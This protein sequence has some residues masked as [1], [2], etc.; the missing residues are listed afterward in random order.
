MR[1]LTTSV[2][3]T[4]PSSNVLWKPGLSRL[5]RLRVATF[6]LTWVVGRAGHCPGA[7]WM[8]QRPLGPAIRLS[9]PR[10]R[11]CARS[12]LAATP[13]AISNTCCRWVIKPLAKRVQFTRPEV[14]TSGLFSLRRAGGSFE[15]DIT[16]CSRH[17]H[18]FHAFSHVAMRSNNLTPGIMGTYLHFG[19]LSASFDLLRLRQAISEQ[20]RNH[21]NPPVASFTP[22]KAERKVV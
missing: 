18:K 21:S 1:A 19:I 6:N 12:K 7:R 10:L 9:T 16:I 17:L 20:N 4:A 13:T 8:G 22:R 2:R 15:A 5:R 3:L 11:Q 14:S